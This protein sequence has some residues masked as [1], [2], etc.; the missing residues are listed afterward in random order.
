[1]PIEMPTESS[2][3]RNIPIAGAK[4]LKDKKCRGVEGQ[5]DQLQRRRRTQV[6]QGVTLQR[7][8]K[9]SLGPAPPKLIPRLSSRS[10]SRMSALPKLRANLAM[11]IA[12]WTVGYRTN[13]KG[14]AQGG[15]FLAFMSG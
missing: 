3:E 4:V 13:G 14:K 8:F 5:R 15:R 1:M 10:R 7:D 12:T 11:W 2:H 6:R 9:A